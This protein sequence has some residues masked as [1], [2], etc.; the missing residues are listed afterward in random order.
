[1][2]Y[3]E[4]SGEEKRRF[5]EEPGA[6]LAM[7]KQTELGMATLFPNFIRGS[8]SQLA[9]Q[10]YM[11]STMESKLQDP[12][13]ARKLIPSFATGCRRFTVCVVTLLKYRYHY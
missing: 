7:R 9:T 11:Q 8:A 5:K 13:L 6:L 3:H 10:K 12:D 2:D 4:Y 1:M